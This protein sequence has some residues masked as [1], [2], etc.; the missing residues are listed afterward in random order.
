M[1]LAQ[2]FRPRL[3]SL[4][5]GSL[6]RWPERSKAM[7]VELIHEPCH[8]WSFGPHHGEVDP[9]TIDQLHDAGDV[10]RRDVDAGGH[11][12]D[13]GIAGRRKQTIDGRVLGDSPRDGVLSPPLTHDENAHRLGSL[14]GL[15]PGW[16]HRD[17]PYRNPREVG[18]APDVLACRRREVVEEPRAPEVSGPTLHVLVHGFGL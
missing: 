3:R 15:L 16:S 18:D 14:H 5:A 10:G 4:Q 7:A 2:L 12:L 11:L 6:C 17:G 8:E 1:L 13:A 9:L